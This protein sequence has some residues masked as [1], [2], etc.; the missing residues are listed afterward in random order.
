MDTP[1]FGIVLGLL[2][3]ATLWLAARGPDRSSG[4]DTEVGL[5]AMLPAS[6]WRAFFG[7]VGVALLAL[8]VGTV[9]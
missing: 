2:A 4:E 1:W 3:L 5:L 6:V 8:A 9:L 7:L